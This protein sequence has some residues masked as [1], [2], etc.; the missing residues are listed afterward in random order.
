MPACLK[1]LTL[2]PG[3]KFQG[4]N[5]AIS[6]CSVCGLAQATNCTHYTCQGLICLGSGPWALQTM[7]LTLQCGTGERP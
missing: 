7:L 2:V 3:I 5:C 4:T 1:T 6:K